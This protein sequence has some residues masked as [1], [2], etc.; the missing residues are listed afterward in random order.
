[1]V[2]QMVRCV[3]E[4]GLQQLPF[5]VDRQKARTAINVFVASHG[6]VASGVSL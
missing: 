2:E 3:F 1:M 4:G 6:C 5:Q